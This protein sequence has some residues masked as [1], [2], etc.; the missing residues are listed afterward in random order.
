MPN[1]ISNQTL[2]NNYQATFLEIKQRI[3]QARYQALKIVNQE[4]NQL[5]LDIGKIVFERTKEGWGSNVV[6]SLSQDLRLEYPGM[7]GLSARSLYRMKLVY[8]GVQE[9]GLNSP[10]LVA[11]IPW[12][13]LSII[14]E[15]VKDNKARMYYLTRTAQEK[16][17]KGVLEEEIS[18][19]SYAKNKNTQSNFAVVEANPEKLQIL[20]N[21]FVNQYDF[22]FLTLPKSH[23]ERE[24]EDAITANIIKF[25]GKLGTNFAFMGRQVP[26]ELPSGKEYFIDLLLYHRK[27]KSLIAVELKNREFEPEFAGKASF[28]LTALDNQMKTEEENPSIGIIICKT[29]D[30][31][32]VEYALRSVS[33]PLVVATYTY[34]QLT[35]EFKALLPSQQDLEVI[36]GVLDQ[37]QQE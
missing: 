13:H 12:T 24:L 35:E 28:Y 7:K 16:W 19:D 15:K 10:L 22:S 9:L 17:S 37:N 3:S 26:I 34:T 4:Q 31:L 8:Q 21:E 29:K 30:K 23:T 27:L 20:Q 1:Q 33:N 18:F 14:I 6:E 11:K 32:E 36:E 2:P 25:L 5:N